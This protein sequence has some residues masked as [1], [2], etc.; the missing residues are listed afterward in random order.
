M[1]QSPSLKKHPSSAAAVGPSRATAAP[2]RATLSSSAAALKSYATPLASSSA[3]NGAAAQATAS[4]MN[5]VGNGSGSARRRKRGIASPSLVL[6]SHDA[7]AVSPLLR[8]LPT[9][10]SPSS[11]A[12]SP[13][14]GSRQRSPKVTTTSSAVPAPP[15]LQQRASSSSSSRASATL[16]NRA[17]LPAPPADG[18]PLA[19]PRG[20]DAHVHQ[21]VCLQLGRGGARGARVR[22]L[23]R[24]AHPSG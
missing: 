12:I 19:A 20:A 8:A 23:A 13:R 11:E 17:P 24:P 9:A 14:R 10:P 2:A 16:L 22:G 21:D 6:S 15:T 4:S 5:A 1:R 7:A 18:A 3:R